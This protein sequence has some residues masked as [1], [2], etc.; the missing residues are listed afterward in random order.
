MA[1]GR[2]MPFPLPLGTDGMEV[3]WQKYLE[4]LKVCEKWEGLFRGKQQVMDGSDLCAASWRVQ[5]DSANSRR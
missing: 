2:E 3:V 1:V 5:S 4:M